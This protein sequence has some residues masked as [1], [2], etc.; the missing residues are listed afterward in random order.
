MTPIYD[1][2]VAE[3]GWT[4]IK[5]PVGSLVPARLV[6]DTDADLAIDQVQR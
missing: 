3:R 6:S 4:H 2:L 1:R 5:R